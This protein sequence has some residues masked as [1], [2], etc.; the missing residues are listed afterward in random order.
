MKV[1]FNRLKKFIRNRQK[2]IKY[3]I[4]LLVVLLCTTYVGNAL[5]KQLNITPENPMIDHAKNNSQIALVSDSRPTS[6]SNEEKNNRINKSEGT[7]KEQESKEAGEGK[8]QDQPEPKE[9]SKKTNENPSD[10]SSD[11]TT[12]STLNKADNSQRIQKPSNE[13]EMQ[14]DVSSQRPDQNQDTIQKPNNA[15]KPQDNKE[16]KSKENDKQDEENIEIVASDNETDSLEANDYFTTTIINKEIVTKKEFSFIVKQKQHDYI[17][18]ELKVYLNNHIESDFTGSVILAEGDNA[19]TVLVTYQD[20]KGK[21][22]S[23]SKDYTVTL[24]KG[25]III[26]SSLNQEMEVTKSELDF[27]ASAQ[28]DDEQIDVAV[29]ANGEELTEDISEGKYSARLNKG[30]NKITISASD[31]SKKSVEQE[32]IVVFNQKESNLKIDTDLK[33]QEVV[34]PTLDFYAIAKDG[35]EQVGLTVEVNGELASDSDK[36]SYSINLQEG[37]N[38]IA[39]KAYNDGDALIQEY[40]VSYVKPTGSEESEVEEDKDAP[41]L[42]TDLVDGTTIRGTIKTFNVWPVDHEGNRIRGGNVI[43][44]VN[45]VGIPFIWDDSTKTSYKLNLQDGKNEVIITV[46][47][48]EGRTITET[49]FVHATKVAEGEVIGKATISIE[50]STIGLGYLI[51]PTEIDIHQGEK[52]SYILDQLLRDNGFTY[53]NTGTLESSF[54]LAA[55]SKPDLVMNPVIPEDLLELV[56]DASTQFDLEN[57]HPDWLGEFDFAN[58][59]GWMYSVNGDYPN[60]GFADSYLLDGDIVRIRYT[61]HYGKDIGGYGSMGRDGDEGGDWYKEW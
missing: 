27:S 38:T 57:Y 4:P 50:A 35:S 49:F 42:V 52:T 3:C 31:G 13:Q 43:V 5:S 54:Y 21:V 55:I 18:N 25:E 56:R 40:E 29:F 15:Q 34:I 60:F 19:I 61:L 44:T 6:K 1:F 59:S 26:Y 48:K 17:V 20:T 33:D 16:N 12:N 46:T 41:S 30:Q 10:K 37:K 8:K 23:V 39:L 24:E 14:G 36:G 53:E 28:R 58:G 47:D 7:S 45:G 51:P 32:Y 22:F 9:T 11:V 2:L